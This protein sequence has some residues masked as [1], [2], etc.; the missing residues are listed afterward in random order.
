MTAAIGL[1]ALGGLFA[2]AI[3]E[4]LLRLLL[5]FRELDAL[6]VSISGMLLRGSWILICLMLGVSSLDPAGGRAFALALLGTYLVGQ[7]GEGVRF[8]RVLRKR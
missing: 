1:G 6:R 5:R 3:S 7:I 8:E 4:A 2:L